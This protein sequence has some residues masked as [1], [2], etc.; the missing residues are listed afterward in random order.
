MNF[1]QALELLKDGKCLSRK[2][3]NGK[4]MY[5]VMEKLY[6]SSNIEIANPCLLL[7]NVSGQYNTWIPSITDIF[8][9]DWMIAA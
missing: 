2:G 8:A 9:E 6:T 7:Y 5:V 1:G 3:W 4:N